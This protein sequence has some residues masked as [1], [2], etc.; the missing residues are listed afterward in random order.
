[1][2]LPSIRCCKVCEIT[3]PISNFTSNRN[4]NNQLN[5]V[6][7]RRHKCV[8]CEKKETK[9]RNKKYYQKKKLTA[10]PEIIIFDDDTPPLD[11]VL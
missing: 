5:G 4:K 11:L 2:P 6:D 1:M 10:Q 7:T 3:M 9:E 8:N